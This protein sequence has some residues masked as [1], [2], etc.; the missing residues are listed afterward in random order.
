MVDALGM[1]E[2][3]QFI[4]NRYGMVSYASSFDVPAILAK[5]TLDAALILQI[6]SGPDPYDST[7]L[8]TSIDVSDLFNDSQSDLTGLVVGI[9]QVY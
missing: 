8:D 3:L 4:N 7:C 5:N 6:I 1:K 9:P 2:G